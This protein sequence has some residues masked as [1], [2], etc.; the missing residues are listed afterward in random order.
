M[1]NGKIFLNLNMRG[2][3]PSFLA[4][5]FL[6]LRNCWQTWKPKYSPGTDVVQSLRKLEAIFVNLVVINLF[7]IVFLNNHI[8]HFLLLFICL[9]NIYCP[10]ICFIGFNFIKFMF[11]LSLGILFKLG[12]IPLF[13]IPFSPF[14][15]HNL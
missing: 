4:S 11:V 2:M 5:I 15:I 13:I 12:F 10:S 1:K 14:L 3:K 9:D 8:L 6:Y 7:H